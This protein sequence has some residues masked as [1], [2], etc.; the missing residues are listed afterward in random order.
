MLTAAPRVELPA[1][2]GLRI[3]AHHTVRIR[4][5]RDT[6]DHLMSPLLGCPYFYLLDIR[7]IITPAISTIKMKSVIICPLCSILLVVLMAEMLPV[8]VPRVPIAK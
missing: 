7:A 8:P 2:I 5:D 3:G 4:T 6:L 1:R